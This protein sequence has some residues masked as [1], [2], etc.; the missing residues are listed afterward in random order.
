MLLEALVEVACAAVPQRIQLFIV[1]PNF[2]LIKV[3]KEFVHR[4]HHVGMGIERSTGK[5]NIHRA[6]V[7][8][9]AHE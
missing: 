6:A 7:I 3:A 5:A 8:V 4:R 9:P 2:R 1:D